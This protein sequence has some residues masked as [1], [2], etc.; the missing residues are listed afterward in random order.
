L[1]LGFCGC[2]VFATSAS[3]RWRVV[4]RVVYAL[5]SSRNRSLLFTD[6]ETKPLLVHSLQKKQLNS[7][8][9]ILRCVYVPL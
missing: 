7:F 3:A 1:V 2:A 8:L 9:R 4:E 6:L 5:L